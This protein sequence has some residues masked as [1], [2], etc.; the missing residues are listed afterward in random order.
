MQARRGNAMENPTGPLVLIVDDE[1]PIRQMERRILQKGGYRIMEAS[2]AAEALAMLGAVNPDLL[3]ADLDMP[4]LCGEEM[5]RRI[6]AVRPNLKVLY[7]TAHID[8]LLDAQSLVW[9]GEAFLDKPFTSAGL[10]EAVALLCTGS[11][12][13]ARPSMTDRRTS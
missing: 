2:G 13:G 12:T 7:V 11:I 4:G 3:I 8:R 9:E 1:A 10:L 5:V 6:H